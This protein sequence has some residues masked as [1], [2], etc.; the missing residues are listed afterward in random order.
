M[1]VQTE[2]YFRVP[3]GKGFVKTFLTI[4][5]TVDSLFFGEFLSLSL[6]ASFQLSENERKILKD[7]ILISYS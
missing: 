3:F 1:L 7:F 6:I 5:R 2:Y 4:Y